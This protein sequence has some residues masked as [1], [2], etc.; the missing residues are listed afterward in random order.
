MSEPT[1]L[2]TVIEK[3]LTETEPDDQAP[4]IVSAVL[5][6]DVERREEQIKAMNDL[7]VRDWED[8]HVDLK[9]WSA[10]FNVRWGMLADLCA[11][12]GNPL[13]DNYLCIDG[14]KYCD[15]KR[16]GDSSCYHAELW[17]ENGN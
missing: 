17:E 6:H 16:P 5:A 11:R 14:Q 15:G 7:L 13:Y 2:Q 10:A 9:L 12:C 8:S 4:K 1:N 3:I